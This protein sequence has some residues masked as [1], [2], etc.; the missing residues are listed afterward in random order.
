MDIPPGVQEAVPGVA[1]TLT[2]LLFVR[3]DGWKR[4]VGTCI[5]GAVIAKIVGP[6]AAV[7]MHSSPAVAG[8]VTGL[9]GMAIVA[10]VFDMIFNFD[11]KQAAKDLWDAVVKR[12][13]GG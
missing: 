3:D 4:V 12:V 1:G 2:A 6:S 7:V 10:K 9:F 13:K 11:A 8:Y 5:A